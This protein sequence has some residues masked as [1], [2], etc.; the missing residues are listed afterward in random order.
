MYYNVE[1]MADG[2]YL[3]GIHGKF[4][5]GSWVLESGGEC[6]V[7][8]MPLA[9]KNEPHP[10]LQVKKFIEDNG[11]RCKY[12]LLS[13]PHL[14]HC[15]SIHQ[16]REVFPA[17]DFSVHYSVPLFLRISENYWGAGKAHKKPET[18]GRI[19]ENI[20]KGRDG[21][22]FLSF[23][24]S[25]FSEDINVLDLGGEPLYMI[26]GPKH[27]LADIHHI[28]KGVWFSGDW[29]L[30]KGDPCIDRASSSKACDSIKRIRDYFKS[31]SYN[32]HSI[33]PAHAN[34]IMRNI[35]FDKILKETYDYH[36][37]FEKKNPDNL[38]WKGFCIRTFYYYTFQHE[39]RGKS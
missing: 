35:D 2:I 4:K 25:L 3:A 1:K 11:W 5:V 8:E 20:K 31:L 7:M 24:N 10:S 33:F 39:F 28:F 16:Y 6:A 22:W 38:D 30:G 32:I 36:E 21:Q 9:S 27:S 17:A 34:N 13:H 12:L 18:S 15:T 37:K 19:W 14:D 23:F 29:W 26:Y